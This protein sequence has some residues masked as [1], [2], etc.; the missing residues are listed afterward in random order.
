MSSDGADA[1]TGEAQDAKRPVP[2]LRFPEF[3]DVGDWTQTKLGDIAPLQ[4][5]FDLPSDQIELARLIHE[6][7]GSV[8]HWVV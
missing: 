2:K 4:R 8:S 5:G 3:L 7:P 6:A 1:V